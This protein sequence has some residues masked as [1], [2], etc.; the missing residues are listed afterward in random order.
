[1]AVDTGDGIV[2]ASS[3]DGSEIDFAGNTIITNF[4]Q[5]ISFVFMQVDNVR[6]LDMYKGSLIGVVMGI[7]DGGFFKVFGSANRTSRRQ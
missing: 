4:S 7:Q 6:T 3:A 2:F 5:A 1:M